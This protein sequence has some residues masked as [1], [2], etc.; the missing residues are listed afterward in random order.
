MRRSKPVTNVQVSWHHGN[1]SYK[2][3]G[4]SYRDIYKIS[5]SV[6]QSQSLIFHEKPSEERPG[7]RMLH[8]SRVAVL[9]SDVAEVT[10]GMFFREKGREK[11][12]RRIYGC[13]LYCVT[14]F[15]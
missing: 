2:I 11:P 12:E 10:K 13:Y 15:L 5:L 3:R 6:Y 1:N 7:A 4:L 14:R 8:L 9:G